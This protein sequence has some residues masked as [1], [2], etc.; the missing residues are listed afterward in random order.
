MDRNNAL[1]CTFV[2]KTFS[3]C[4]NELCLNLNIVVMMI[5]HSVH[6]THHNEGISNEMHTISTTTEATIQHETGTNTNAA[7]TL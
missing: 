3:I 2:M 1:K 6:S 5:V 4:C 7:L